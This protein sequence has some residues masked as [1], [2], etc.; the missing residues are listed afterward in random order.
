MVD[1]LREGLTQQARN[2]H[3]SCGMAV[4]TSC[5]LSA[6]A[7]ICALLCAALMG[8][9]NKP[10][11]SA[12]TGLTYVRTLGGVEEY[13][14]ETNSLS[15]LLARN[16]GVSVVTANIHYMAG[17]RHE[18]TGTTGTA[19]L[20][21]HLMF[22][23]TEKYNPENGTD[24]D[25]TLHVAGV[26][27]NA[28]VS[29][30]RSAYGATVAKEYLETVLAIEADRMRNQPIREE[31]RRTEMT[32]VRNEYERFVNNP[33]A[34]LTA[35][36]YAAAFQALPYRHMPIGWKSDIERVPI[37]KIQAFYDSYYWPN[38]AVL[39]INGDVERKEALRLVYKYFAEVPRSPSPIPQVYTEEP[40]QSGPRRVVVKRPGQVGTVMIAHK[41]PPARHPDQAALAVLDGILGHGRSSRLSRALVDTGLA[42]DVESETAAMHDLSLHTITAR[43]GPGVRHEQVEKALLAELEWI[44]REGVSAAE[45]ERVQHQYRARQAYLRDGTGEIASALGESAAT[46]DWALY[47]TLPALVAKIRPE[48]VRR[49]AHAR[50][51][52]DQSTTG[53]F[54]P[55]NEPE[56]RP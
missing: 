48:D 42:L 51:N 11:S 40:L 10:D 17:S 5:A 15:V 26:S 2:W 56:R 27:P 39:I 30:D 24:I 4:R 53:W 37:E 18:V 36:V 29:F 1:S 54:V 34:V 3:D 35:E 9:S 16:A 13:R 55:V 8:C 12:L 52:G 20:L 19:H 33:N 45:V 50:L 38:N 7:W 21:E 41:V 43:V 44:R 49:V 25:S 28:G 31:D 46:G 23:G 47:H 6:R 14:L 22:M 32:T